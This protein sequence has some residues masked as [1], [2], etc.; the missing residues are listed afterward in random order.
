MKFNDYFGLK[1]MVY[2][3][4]KDAKQYLNAIKQQQSQQK[5]GISPNELYQQSVNK[6]IMAVLDPLIKAT[7]ENSAAIKDL[8]FRL[9]KN[10]KQDE[11]TNSGLEDI[12]KKLGER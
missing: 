11:K 9:H 1:E 3:T 7:E 10:E 12:I 6:Q 2:M 5:S 4:E 8:Y